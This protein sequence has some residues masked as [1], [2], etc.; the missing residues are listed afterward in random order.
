MLDYL[1][2]Q[3]HPTKK[4]ALVVK[5]V[6][7]LGLKLQVF[8]CTGVSDWGFLQIR[9]PWSLILFL[10]VLNLACKTYSRL[11]LIYCK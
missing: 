9:V 5:S 3:T 4:S 10:F 8:A 6:Q 11:K 2:K 7:L 1:G